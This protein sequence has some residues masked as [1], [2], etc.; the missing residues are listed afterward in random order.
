[1]CFL[2][3]CT[4]S[5]VLDYSIEIPEIA[6]A[7]G[8]VAVFFFYTHAGNKRCGT[9]GKDKQESMGMLFGG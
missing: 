9:A 7:G 2:Y 8:G 1:M 6:A 5:L 3:V 4:L